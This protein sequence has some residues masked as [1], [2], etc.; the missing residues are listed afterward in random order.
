MAGINVLNIRLFAS[1]HSN[2]RVHPFIM[3]PSS[4]SVVWTL[5]LL[6]VDVIRTRVDGCAD[7]PWH[8]HV[9]S[10]FLKSVFKQIK[11]RWAM[12]D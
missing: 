10:L 11:L 12:F 8:Q 9:V 5:S 3:Y 1:S 7:I 2:Q 6:E 4:E